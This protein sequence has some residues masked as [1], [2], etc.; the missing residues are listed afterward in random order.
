M[1]STTIRARPNDVVLLFFLLAIIC[2][3]SKV[4]PHLD[5][6]LVDTTAT[7]GNYIPIIHT[8]S[9]VSV[10]EK[11]KQKRRSN[12]NSGDDAEGHNPCL[13]PHPV[14][15]ESSKVVVNNTFLRQPTPSVCGK[16]Q[17]EWNT[18]HNNNYN[19]NE[20]I[21]LSPLARRIVTH[22]T[23]CSLPIATYHMDNSF[24]L[25]SHL[26]VWSQALC[27][28]WEAGYRIQTYN[29]S[30]L[31]LDQTYCDPNQAKESP[32][33][34]YFPMAE[35]Q[36]S[37]DFNNNKNVTSF[38]NVSDPKQSRLRCS[39]LKEQ[40]DFVPHFRAASMEFLFR[41]ISPIIVQEAERQIGLLFG[42]KGIVPQDLITVHMRWGDKFWEM[43]LASEHEYVAAVSKLILQQRQQQPSA[44]GSNTNK[45]IDMG[46]V[47]A[48]AANIY[49]ATEDPRAVHA[50]RKAA[51]PA[52][53]IFVDRTIAELNDFRPVKHNRASWTTRNTKGRAG[54][55]ALGSLLVALEANSFVLT[56]KSN[57]SRLINELR[58]NIVDRQCNNCTRMIDLRPGQW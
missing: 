24:G 15:A 38:V 20:A 8:A 49:L 2:F 12:N 44:G 27:N 51:P 7:A 53:N 57:W 3:I 1:A 50:F 5:H 17:R 40:P 14:H 11:Q 18:V 35:S 9:V 36:C 48:T 19:N 29:P 33:L 23:N 39:W 30:W 28:A 58:R 37:D 34:C 26:N 46:V 56:T 13:V 21:F 45:K 31:W 25:G 32:L 43:D 10:L 55:V 42:S 47:N 16:L 41:Q 22:Q 6:A 52:W 54:L 4:L